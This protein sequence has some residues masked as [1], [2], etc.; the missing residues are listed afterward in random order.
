M[1]FHGKAIINAPAK[2]VYRT[3]LTT[4]NYPL[5]DKNCI[6][7][8]GN[9]KLGSKILLHS[10]TDGHR[11]I[12]IKVSEL[13]E[14]KKIVWETNLPFKI[15]SVVRTFLIIAKDDYTTEFHITEVSSGF[16]LPLVKQKIPDM[17]TYFTDFARGLKKF[18][19]SRSS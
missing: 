9:I 4:E 15:V 7:I 18:I 17:N 10:K 1:E 12:R 6:K 11:K 19:E 2:E 3:L 5:F 14:N 8:S 16:L 13:I